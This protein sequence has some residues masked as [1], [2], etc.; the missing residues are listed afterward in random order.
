MTSFF[1]NLKLNRKLDQF[2]DKT[3]KS[4]SNLD[5]IVGIIGF[6]IDYKKYCK[7][8]LLSPYIQIWPEEDGRKYESMKDE[9][10]ICNKKNAQ[11]CFDFVIDSSLQLQRFDFDITELEKINIITL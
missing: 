1:M 3:G 11:F 4:F 2:I 8:K 10:I 5:E 9:Q 7:F 6:G